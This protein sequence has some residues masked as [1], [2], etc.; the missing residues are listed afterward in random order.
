M[1]HGV[2]ALLGLTLLA[3]CRS[4]EPK[5]EDLAMACQISK[6]TCVGERSN[7]FST[8]ETANVLFRPDGSA[9]CGAGMKLARGTAAEVKERRY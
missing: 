2:P 9:Y 6:C 5:Q 7:F 1:K 3:A 8:P 4:P